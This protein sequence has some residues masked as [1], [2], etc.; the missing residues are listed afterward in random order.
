MNLRTC[1]EGC[2]RE[3][4][5]SNMVALRGNQPRVDKLPTETAWQRWDEQTERWRGLDRETRQDSGSL[6]WERICGQEVLGCKVGERGSVFWV[7]SDSI[8]PFTWIPKLNTDA[9][10]DDADRAYTVDT[11][12]AITCIITTATLLLCWLP[13]V[14]QLTRTL[15]SVLW[16]YTVFN[17]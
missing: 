2:N 14:K 11:D 3:E 12:L 6:D 9:F 10:F 8:C 17:M 5:N 16:I 15:W 4:G 7:C 13:C 1:L